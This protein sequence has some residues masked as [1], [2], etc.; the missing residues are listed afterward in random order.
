[1]MG[2]GTGTGTRRAC[3]APLL[4]VGFC[5]SY[6]LTHLHTSLLRVCLH[7]LQCSQSTTALYNNPAVLG[8]AQGQDTQGCT[9]LLAYLQDGSQ[10]WLR[11][12]QQTPR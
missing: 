3:L 5:L 12:G 11:P 10:E 4:H 9:A 7:R 1:M 8:L 2:M 6:F